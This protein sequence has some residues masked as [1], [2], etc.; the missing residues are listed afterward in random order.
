MNPLQG[1]CDPAPDVVVLAFASGRGFWGRP[2]ALGLGFLHSDG[3]VAVARLSA[4]P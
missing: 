2:G 3:T 4:R 1:C